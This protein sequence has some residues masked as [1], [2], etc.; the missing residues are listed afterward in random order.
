[1][2]IGLPL[3]GG[4]LLGAATYYYWLHAPLPA[5][6]PL[7]ATPRAGSLL[8]GARRRTYRAYVPA[9]LPPGAPLVLAL[10]G[11]NQD[12]ATLRRWMGYE[13]DEL[14]DRYGFAVA[15]PDGYRGNWN[16][17]RRAATFPAKTE[18]VDDVGF[19]RA[20]VAHC[21]T[22]YGTDP[23]RTYAFGFSNGGQMAFRLAMEEPRLVAAIATAGANLPP[24][25]S[26][27]CALA[28]PTAR[29]L[30]VA[31]T[32]DPISPYAGGRVTLFG[33][34]NR[35]M[36]LSARATAEAFARRNGLADSPVATVLPHQ[37]AADPTAVAQLTWRR[38]G[39]PVVELFT[40]RGGGHVV[41]Q[42]RFRFPRL[43]GRTTADLDTPARAIAFFGLDK[44]PVKLLAE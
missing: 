27:T 6:P 21:R 25:E 9:G 7:S 42:P 28:G 36:A 31:G 8:V 4:L 22:E 19:L 13:L 29:V 37:R 10:H 16:N 38:D 35:G 12:G 26:C 3:A 11:S 43:L 20:L 24:P 15:Y 39:E 1:M 33:F 14:A 17:C 40:G 34:G 41:P 2:K 18:N 23:G 5:V 32:Q 44:G 30:L